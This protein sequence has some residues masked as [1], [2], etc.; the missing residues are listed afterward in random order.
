MKQTKQIAEVASGVLRCCDDA[1]RIAANVVL[2]FLPLSN[3]LVSK[4][5]GNFMSPC[6]FNDVRSYRPQKLNQIESMVTHGANLIK[7]SLNWSDPIL[8]IS[9]LFA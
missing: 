2:P 4:S 5:A 3:S 7:T 1:A 9:R 8:V 6:A